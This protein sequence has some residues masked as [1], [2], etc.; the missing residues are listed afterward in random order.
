VVNLKSSFDFSGMRQGLLAMGSLLT[1]VPTAPIRM[2]KALYRIY[3]DMFAAAFK[4]K[5]RADEIQAA[6]KKR[7]NWTTGADKIAKIEYSDI[8]GQRFTRNEENARSVLDEWAQLP[9]IEAGKPI[10]SAL[11]AL[12]KLGSRGVAASNRAF[13]TFL[14][15]TRATL[16]DELL[17]ANFPPDSR[18]PTDNELRIIGN[19]VNIATGR[20]KLNPAVAK[21]AAEMIWAP[22][23]LASRLQFLLG[24]PLWGGGVLRNSA[25]A[26]MIIAKEY[27][28]VIVSGILLASVARLFD[29]KK[30]PSPLSS[31]FGK[32]VRGNTRIDLWGGLQQATVLLSRLAAGKTKTLKGREID[33]VKAAK[34]GQPGLMV[35]LTNFLR[36]KLRPDIGIAIDL[37]TRSGYTE[38][39]VAGIAK[40]LL[41]PLPF[42]DIV[43]LAKD[44]G[45]P[46][47][48]VLEALNQFGAG[49]SVYEPREKPARERRLEPS[50]ELRVQ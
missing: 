50:R 37:A 16:F 40:D 35:V 20:G 48:L 29:D 41:V 43:A 4:G 14:N 10:K 19:W 31:D 45:I 25:R 21:G 26:R 22:K 3:S 36:T 12:P 47:T 39:T 44:R 1:R 30:E 27:A 2:T 38:P 49:V 46:E 15:A 7:P 33:L 5:D 13:A 34:A 9:I 11:T 8:Q 32:I 18:P 42:V 23:L 6:L 28:R 24:Q 17:A